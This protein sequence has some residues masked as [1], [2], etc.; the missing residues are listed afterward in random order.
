MSGG[1]VELI[2]QARDLL[3]NDLATQ[4]EA[5]SAFRQS[6]PLVARGTDEVNPRQER[7]TA[8]EG[9]RSA[10][11]LRRAEVRR[12]LL[13][14]RHAQE[15]GADPA[16]LLGL[17][18]DLRKQSIENNA[19]GNTSEAVEAQ[20]VQLLDNEHRLLEN[21]G[22]N[23][24]HVENIRQRI[25]AAR[26]E[27]ALPSSA[28]LEIP[29]SV[30]PSGSNDSATEPV[31]V[32]TDYLE[33]ELDRLGIAEGL[34]AELYD[35]EH[36]AAKELST[37]QLKDESFRRNIERSE[38]LYDVVVNR[39]QEASL[40]K[41]FGGFETRVIA[42]PR[43]G[44]K[45]SP[46]RKIVL[47]LSA[48]AGLLFGS[49]LALMIDVRD[50]RFYSAGEIL[51]EMGVPVVGQI[52]EFGADELRRQSAA[53]DMTRADRSLSTVLAPRSKSAEA[54]RSLRTALFFGG[55]AKS[56]RVVQVSGAVAEDGAST[57]AAN[58]AI[59]LAQTGKRV[60]L[61]DANLKQQRQH[62]LFGLAQSESGFAAMIHSNLDPAEGIVATGVP[63]LALLS[64]GP[65]GDTPMEWFTTR[66]FGELIRWARDAYDYVLID[67]EPW[68][69]ASDPGV[70]APQTDGVLLTLRL[71]RDSRRHASQIKA[72]L[73][74][75]QVKPLGVVVNWLRG[76]LPGPLQRRQAAELD[77]EVPQS[78][79]R[80]DQSV[81]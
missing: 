34:L 19:P 40:V 31:A 27:F 68:L 36:E 52:P 2:K 62:Q 3:K 53:L 70:I 32:Y 22:P 58:L 67:T 26:R 4:E 20:L 15:G 29:T 79:M 46:S 18:S 7:L 14:I 43:L 51:E 37:Y 8:I 24:P 30:K 71:S 75:L 42:P 64:A 74:L 21:Y 41:D 13:A 76:V 55:L 35:R 47:P 25:E 38:A 69:A 78:R 45:V 80:S 72:M 11:L 28:R 17:I 65:L 33:Q 9:Q 50:E 59:S 49:M 12:Q 16:R 10:V 60:L 57:V 66:R 6:S 23:H 81:S 77:I 44:E 54:F 48:L 61:I 56:S 63:S 39:L 73:D 1:T 5:Y